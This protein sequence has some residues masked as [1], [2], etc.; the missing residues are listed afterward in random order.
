[1]DDTDRMDD[2]EALRHLHDGGDYRR[3]A[4]RTSNPEVLRE[5]AV[6]AELPFVWHAIARNT[7]T[8][9]E[10]LV[11]LSTRRHTTSNDNCLLQLV[12]AHPALTGPDLDGL[13]DVLAVRLR[14]GDRPYAAVLELA[15]RPEPAVERLNW[16]GHLQGASTSLRRGITRALAT[17]PDR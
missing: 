15:R 3:L 13:V 17:R 2:V 5:L 11:A 6:R 1:M 7:A 16:L 10:V 12:A 4:E 14:E 9:A 8:P